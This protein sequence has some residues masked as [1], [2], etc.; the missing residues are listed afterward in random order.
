[1]TDTLA[2]VVNAVEYD[3][4]NTVQTERDILRA[5]DLDPSHYALYW[6]A[7]VETLGPEQRAGAYDGD[8]YM[9]VPRMWL[10]DEVRFKSQKSAIKLLIAGA[11][12]DGAAL[13][14][15]KHPAMV[16]EVVEHFGTGAVV[17]LEGNRERKKNKTQDIQSH[18]ESD[19]LI[20]GPTT[21]RMWS[22][23]SVVE[24][25]DDTLIDDLCMV[26]EATTADG[27]LKYQAPR[28]DE[29]HADS[30][31]ALLLAMAAVDEAKST[32]LGSINF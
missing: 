2:I 20:L 8:H 3:I 30:Y 1:M 21:V 16:E 12:P 11:D 13:D 23:G 31:S 29:G 4:P 32:Y 5:V 28:G 18:I 14:Q 10:F 15:T 17:G 22:G 19:A 24:V 6:D 27:N 25:E 26:E 7:D 9:Y